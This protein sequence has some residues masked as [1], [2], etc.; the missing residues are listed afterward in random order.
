MKTYELNARDYESIN[1]ELYAL[2]ETYDGV[3][4]N[5]H[6]EVNVTLENGLEVV[7]NVK[8]EADDRV[9]CPATYYDPEER[10]SNIN[11]NIEEVYAWQ[12]E[13]VAVMCDR[14]KITAN[15]TF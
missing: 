9:I 3:D 1:D 4:G 8:I 13:E 12:G 11:L 7:C 6:E 5:Y 15:Y 14:N 10:G 2:A